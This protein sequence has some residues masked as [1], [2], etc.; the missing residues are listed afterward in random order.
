MEDLARLER[1]ILSKR[2]QPSLGGPQTLR[3]T[4]SGVGSKKAAK[5]ANG[6]FLSLWWTSGVARNIAFRSEVNAGRGIWFARLFALA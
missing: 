4:V 2:S 3:S 5:N 1:A 6:P